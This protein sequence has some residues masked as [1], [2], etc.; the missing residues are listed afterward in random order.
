MNAIFWGVSLLLL[1]NVAAGLAFMMRGRGGPNSLL[2]A[3]LLGTTGVAVVAVLA[4]ALPLARA[5]D[6]A[7]VFALLA[8]ILGVTFALRGW[9]GKELDE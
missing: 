7:L 6:V 8:P 9:P 1:L 5:L 3:L 4:F 2:A